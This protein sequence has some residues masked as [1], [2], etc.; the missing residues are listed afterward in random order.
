MRIDASA[1]AGAGRVS[2]DK[3][4]GRLEYDLF[5]TLWQIIV[6]LKRL[7]IVHMAYFLRQDRPF[8]KLRRYIRR[9]LT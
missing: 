5:G 6:S 1:L 3:Q 8:A 2:T 4:A 9:W 7:T